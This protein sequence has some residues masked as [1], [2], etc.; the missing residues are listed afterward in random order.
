MG[1]IY[2]NSIKYSGTTGCFVKPEI[3]SLTEREIGVY[4]NGKPLYEKT[5]YARSISIS[6]N[7]K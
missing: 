5:I 1:Q 4:Q 2:L 7:A 6:E 3:Y